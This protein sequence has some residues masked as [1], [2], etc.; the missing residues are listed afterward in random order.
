M[1]TIRRTRGAPRAFSDAQNR[2]LRAGLNELHENRGGSQKALGDEIGL[3]QQA[4]QRL[5]K[6]RDAGFS[7]ETATRVVRALKFASVDTF[8]RAKGV[9]TPS[10]PPVAAAK[11][12]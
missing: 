9:A 7:Y 10:E 2:A 11:S 8:F 3:T 12:A 5:L 1:A 6:S 4:I